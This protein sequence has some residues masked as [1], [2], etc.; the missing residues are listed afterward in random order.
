[1]R[2]PLCVSCGRRYPPY[3]DN[4]PASQHRARRRYTCTTCRAPWRSG[5]RTAPDAAAVAA[6]TSPIVRGLST[7][8]W[9]TT[10]STDRRT[11]NYYWC[12]RSAHPRWNLHRRERSWSFRG[13]WRTV[14]LKRTV[15]REHRA[16]RC[17]RRV[18]STPSFLSRIC[19]SSRRSV[20]QNTRNLRV[21]SSFERSCFSRNKRNVKLFTMTRVYIWKNMS[22]AILI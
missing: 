2:R 14:R 13:G 20:L 16:T 15:P 11:L 6:S 1:M 18:K 12:P 19:R 22:K 7:Y 9:P 3:N 21:Q 4:H 17:N 5:C 8:Y 10:S